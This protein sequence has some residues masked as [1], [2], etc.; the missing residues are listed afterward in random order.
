MKGKGQ[1]VVTRTMT[2]YVDDSKNMQ[3][4]LIRVYTNI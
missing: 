4:K 2:E 1:L 3:L